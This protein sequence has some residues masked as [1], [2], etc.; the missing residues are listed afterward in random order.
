M[1]ISQQML[2]QN[3]LRHMN[4]NLSRMEKT[5]LDLSTGKKLHKPSDDPNGVSKAMNLKSALTANKQYERNADEANLWLSE[6]D[7]TINGMVE[8]MQRVR[9]L[10]VQGNNGA[11][12]DQDRNMIAS[13]T[14]ALHEQIHQFAN[15]KVNGQYLFN[16]SNTKNPPFPTSG[17]Y[18]ESTF[19]TD[20][21]K[22]TIGEGAAV[23]I[24]VTAD[25]LIGNA[26]ENDNLFNVL[27]SV[28]AALKAGETVSLDHIDQGMERLLTTAAE[29]G[30]RQN[31]VEAITNRV[32]DSN[33]ALQTMLSQ[34]ED[35][36]YAETITKLKSEESI[37]QASL[38]A[39]AKIIQPTLMDFLR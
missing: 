38:S 34:I 29:V 15:A 21:R 2:H 8:V 16:G 5:N 23:N 14:E 22:F 18:T 10:A 3:S 31:R 20:Q 1:R 27:N 25:K 39:T 11:L 24:N 4:Q 17:A 28:A 19:N 13:E 6:A 37:Y 33:V 12:S 32:Q 7:Q 9:E 36:N 35:V 30:A 26:N